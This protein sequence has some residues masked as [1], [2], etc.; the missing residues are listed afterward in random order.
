[1]FGL[2]RRNK[3]H[4]I[5]GVSSFAMSLLSVAQHLKPMKNVEFEMANQ[6]L[7]DVFEWLAEQ[8]ASNWL[9][10]G[11]YLLNDQSIAR[12]QLHLSRYLGA[13]T[14]PVVFSNCS[15]SILHALPML[16]IA[17]Q[18]LGIVHI[19]N[20]FEVKAS[21]EPEIGSAFHFAL[22][23]FNETR[24][25]CLGIDKEDQSDK[26]LEYAEDLGCDWM[27]LN[28]CQF[29]H[30][31]QVKQQLASYLAHCDQIVLNIDLASLAPKSRL[32]ASRCVDVQLVN[33][34]IR[35]ALVSGKVKMIQL[36]GWKDKHIFAKSTLSILHEIA[37][38]VPS[39]DRAA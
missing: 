8:E 14:L 37:S 9:N 33:R 7:E 34:I 12:Y 2:F 22:A 25:F 15:E 27:T 36:V 13:H 4:S 31:F 29:S 24:L 3:T 39:S 1:M 6:S 19:G 17:N 38:M 23:R 5:T 26:I 16:N 30:R 32:E 35:Q 28:E 20:Q 18:D 21:L 10:G 11:H